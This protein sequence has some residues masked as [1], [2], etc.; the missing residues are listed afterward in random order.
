MDGTVDPGWGRGSGEGRLVANCQDDPLKQRDTRHVS[1]WL[2]PSG[3]AKFHEPASRQLC[4]K[5]QR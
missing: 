4:L 5:V 3:K 1:G 2:D